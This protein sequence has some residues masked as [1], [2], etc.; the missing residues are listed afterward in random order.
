MAETSNWMPFYIGDY[1]RDTG[2]LTTLEHGGYILLLIH[3]WTRGGELPIDERRLRMIAKME[4]KEWKAAA[5]AILE[6]F[7]RVGDVLRNK[8]LD[9]EYAKAQSMNEQRKAA[10]QASAEARARQ[11]NSNE[12]ANGHVNGN[13]TSVGTVDAPPLARNSRP[14]QP[15]LQSKSLSVGIEGGVGGEFSLEPSPPAKTATGKPAAHSRAKPRSAIPKDWL[16]NEADDDYACERLDPNV[17]GDVY[18]TFHNHHTAKGTLMADWS[19][20]WRTWV[21]NEVKFRLERKGA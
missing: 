2:H 4:A 3:A 20:A 1:L 8:R 5:P 13:S 21:N 7:H 18:E 15:Q 11:R 14:L 19:A 17:V 6:Y 16:P 12:H 9:R 10:G